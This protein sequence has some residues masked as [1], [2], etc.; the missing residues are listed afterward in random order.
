MI[1][2]IVLAAVALIFA[3]LTGWLIALRSARRAQRGLTAALAVADQRAA[4]ADVRLAELVQHA[5]QRDGEIAASRD[6]TAKACQEI[7]ALRAAHAVAKQAAVQQEHAAKL[8]QRALAESTC[9]QASLRAELGIVQERLAQRESGQAREGRAV[10]EMQRVLAPLI[11]R[12]RLAGQL[13][14]LDV[15]RGTRGELPRV[16]DAIAT[17]GGFSTVVLS[18][19]AG[20]PLA[21]NQGN[22]DGEQLAGLWSLLLTVADRVAAAGAPV[23]V[24]IVVHDAANQTILH[25]LFT[26]AGNQFLLTAVSRGRSL[27]PEALDPALAKLERMLAGSALAS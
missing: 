13:A 27:A 1:G 2:F 22:S 17:V 18:D 15:G 20:L 26:S 16:M 6:D 5:Q 23:P 21:V 8:A 19:E 9:A 25:R 12:E 24:A 10:E 3:G 7:G 11:E 14:R 4:A